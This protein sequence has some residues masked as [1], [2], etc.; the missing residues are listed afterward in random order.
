MSGRIQ[1]CERDRRYTL[2]SRCP[3]CGGPTR[4]AHPARYSPQDRYGA[5]RRLAKRW[6]T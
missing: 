3:V 1:Y 5:Y 2:F 4:T 6:K